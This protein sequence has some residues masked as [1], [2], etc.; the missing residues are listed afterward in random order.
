MG[1]GGW[2]GAASWAERLA[3]LKGRNNMLV[4]P[5]AKWMPRSVQ[6]QLEQ[7]AGVKRALYMAVIDGATSADGRSEPIAVS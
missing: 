5:T 4:L 1:A 6:H 2:P 7:V 3:M